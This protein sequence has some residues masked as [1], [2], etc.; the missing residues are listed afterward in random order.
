MPGTIQRQVLSR[1]SAPSSQQEP[2]SSPRA[3]KTKHAGPDL[4][5]LARQV[6]AEVRRRLAAEWERRR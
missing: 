1:D 4:D 6:Y 2:D 5:D 3:E